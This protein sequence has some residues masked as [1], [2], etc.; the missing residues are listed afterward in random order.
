MGWGTAWIF[1]R[2]NKWDLPC[3]PRKVKP[4]AFYAI[5]RSPYAVP[6]PL[7][8]AWQ[9]LRGAWLDSQETLPEGV[10]EQLCLPHQMST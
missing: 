2:K 6:S 4:A 9:T 3:R 1:G 8:T 10:C 5:P 7:T